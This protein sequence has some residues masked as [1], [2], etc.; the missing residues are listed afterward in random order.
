ML[1]TKPQKIRNQKICQFEPTLK[2]NLFG[3]W[4]FSTFFQS[5]VTKV[6]EWK[7]AHIEWS[8]NVQNIRKSP[9]NKGFRGTYCIPPFW[10]HPV[11]STNHPEAWSP[12][13]SVCR[14]LCEGLE[15][16]GGQPG[17]EVLRQLG[18][19]PVRGEHGVLH[20]RRGARQAAAWHVTIVTV[21]TWHVTRVLTCCRGRARGCRGWAPPARR[22][23]SRPGAPAPR[24]QSPGCTPYIVYKDKYTRII[25]FVVRDR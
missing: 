5:Y 3:D 19:Q 11:D 15:L 14:L 6:P 16:G 23:R 8:K 4:D 25:I 24:P 22:G 12:G 17:A 13:V 10:E 1:W 7:I 18:Q 2:S 9:K 21:Y 20:T